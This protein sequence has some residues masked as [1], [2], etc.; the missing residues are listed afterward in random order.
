M[1]LG[2]VA[3]KQSNFKEIHLHS[4]VRIKHENKQSKQELNIKSNDQWKDI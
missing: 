3:N 2:H 4:I 1:N